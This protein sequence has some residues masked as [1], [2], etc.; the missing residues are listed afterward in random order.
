M[1]RIQV[2]KGV[3]VW[4]G[5]RFMGVDLAQWLEAEADTDGLLDLP[6]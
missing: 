2:N 3:R 5:M 1:G 4:P 6:E